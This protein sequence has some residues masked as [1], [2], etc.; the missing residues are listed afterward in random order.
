MNGDARARFAQTAR[1]GG[2]DAAAGAGDEDG[3][4]GKIDVQSND[5][6]KATR[7]AQSLL[8]PPGT[9]TRLQAVALLQR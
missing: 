7:C 4:S 3:L 1:D 9:V 5:S 8:V 6:L 2:A